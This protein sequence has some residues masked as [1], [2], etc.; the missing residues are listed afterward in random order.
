MMDIDM[1]TEDTTTPTSAKTSSVT[2]L[3][4]T[5]FNQSDHCNALSSGTDQNLS[6]NSNSNP[7]PILNP[8][9]LSPNS[10]TIANLNPN[11]NTAKTSPNA[12]PTNPN[13][14]SVTTNPLFGTPI[15]TPSLGN[16]KLILNNVSHWSRNE[17]LTNSGDS[18]R[19]PRIDDVTNDGITRR[20][21]TVDDVTNRNLGNRQLAFG[22]LT[23]GQLDLTKPEV[24][25]T[26]RELGLTNSNID[27]L[28]S[29]FNQSCSSGIVNQYASSSVINPSNS[30]VI[31][32]NNPSISV[33]NK[34]TSGS[35]ITNNNALNNPITNKNT[36]NTSVTNRSDPS[37]SVN[38]NPLNTSLTNINSFTLPSRFPSK[39]ISQSNTDKCQRSSKCHINSHCQ[40]NPKCHSSSKCQSNTKCQ[41]NSKCQG[42]RCHSN[43]KCQNSP[44]C[45]NNGSYGKCQGHS[46]NAE[47]YS[48]GSNDTFQT[49]DSHCQARFTRANS[50]TGEANKA[51]FTLTGRNSSEESSK[52]PFTRAS[53]SIKTQFTEATS[54]SKAQFT[55]T[56]N[57]CDSSEA[58]FTRGSNASEAHF[59][60]SMTTDPNESY[61]NRQEIEH[62]FNEFKKISLAS[63]EEECFSRILFKKMKL[64]GVSPSVSS[65]GVACGSSVASQ[66]VAPRVDETDDDTDVEDVFFKSPRKPRQAKCGGKQRVKMA[67]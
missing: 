54:T 60:R 8:S 11:S 32:N 56:S 41:G 51:L 65:R 20:N 22:G 7:N 40:E 52:A 64:S 46:Q 10:N 21:P 55:R 18:R 61:S 5:I 26:D 15:R 14:S 23:E 39:L 9:K 27:N 13:S 43:S 47:I 34:N 25:L 31:L 19:Q 49:N 58:P 53:N 36:F 3:N 24:G 35:S 57:T 62:F 2:N 17:R 29:R 1:P 30:S 38:T 59:T 12:N 16:N 37:T 66:G 33:T 6:T 67:A 45:Q 28:N 50:S 48:L 4:R 42:N 63:D 44:E